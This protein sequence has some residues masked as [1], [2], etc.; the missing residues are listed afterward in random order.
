MIG[1]FEKRWRLAAVMAAGLIAAI[2]GLSGGGVGIDRLLRTADFALRTHVASGNLVIVEIDARSIASIDRWPWPRSNYA[3]V[4]DRIR[5]ADAAA[6]AFDV[7]FS[8]YSTPDDDRRF[9]DSLRRAGGMVTLPTFGQVADSGQEEWAEALPI[10]ILRA[11][12]NLAA[13]NIRPN[14]DGQVRRAPLGVVTGG[15]PRP[16]IAAMVAGRAGTADRDFEI[17]FAI[18][19]TTIPRLSFVD[20]RDGRFDRRAIAG[21]TVVIG[22]TAVELGDRYAV[23]VHGVIPGVV[24]QAIAAETL[25]NGIPVDAGWVFPFGLAILLSFPI[26][27]ART[28]A[29]LIGAGIGAP[30]ALLA[31]ALIGD[32]MARWLFTLAPALIMLAVI[33]IIAAAKRASIALQRARTIDRATGMPNRAALRFAIERDGSSQVVAAHI[34]DFDKLLAGVGEVAMASLVVR[35]GDRIRLANGDR[36]VFRIEDRLL[37]WRL[38]G[39][40]LPEYQLDP[41]QALMLSP[42][43]ITGRRVDVKLAFGVAACVSSAELGIAQATLAASR[44]LSQGEGWHRHSAEENAVVDRELSLLTELDEAIDRGEIE[45]HYQPKLDLKTG[46]IG[47]VE[48]LVRWN[49]ATLGRLPPDQFIPLAECNDRIAKLTLHV[50]AVT[51][52]D[53]QKW[54]AVGHSLTGA[55]NISAKLLG[56]A[57]FVADLRDQILVSGIAPSALVLEVT[58]SATLSDPIEA[59]R[60]LVALR[61]IGLSISMDDYGTGQSTLTYLK[62]LPLNELKIDRSFVQFAHVNR[63]DGALVRSTIGLAHELGLKVVAEGVEDQPCLDFLKAAGCDMAQGYHI[64]RPVPAAALTAILEPIKLQVA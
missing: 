19:P 62:Q 54:H 63:G 49:H 23:P 7:D 15:V 31:A 57:G 32:L 3:T 24:I 35:L 46:M 22:A 16:S 1:V 27:Q 47:S 8:A 14:A 2:V 58:E 39:N 9:A 11:H 5:G 18:D 17:D 21:K 44:A 53:L 26:L 20:I 40:D 6:I 28:R 41:L 55:V 60:A 45:V 52:A 42:I 64:S 48:A 29:G 12:A 56:S 36:E 43:E 37:A 38:G 51:I 50:M 30:V 13:V 4:V 61:S 34:V 59:V 33:S 25:W 10:P